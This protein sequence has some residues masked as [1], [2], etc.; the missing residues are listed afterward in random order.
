MAEKIKKKI[1]DESNKIKAE[2]A[3]I[4]KQIGDAGDNLR[5]RLGKAVGKSNVKVDDNEEPD[6]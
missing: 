3:K 4:G 6:D 2:E 1:Q 5:A